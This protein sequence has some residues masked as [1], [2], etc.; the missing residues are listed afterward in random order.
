MKAIL[1]L[2]NFALSFIGLCIDPHSAPFYAPIIGVAWFMS[3][4]YLLQRAHKN[5]TMDRVNEIMKINEL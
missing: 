3:A 1:I 4:C 5:G 2:T